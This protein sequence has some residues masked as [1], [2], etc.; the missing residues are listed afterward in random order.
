MFN[1]F[2]PCMLHLDFWISFPLNFILAIRTRG[3][4]DPDLMPK[5][6][7]EIEIRPQSLEIILIKDLWAGRVFSP[8][9]SGEKTRAVNWWWGWWFV[10]R[11]GACKTAIVRVLSKA[12]RRGGQIWW[13]GLLQ[14]GPG[15]SPWYRLQVGDRRV[16]SN[17]YCAS[18]Y[19]AELIIKLIIFILHLYLSIQ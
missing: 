14:W 18:L 1:Y 6:L 10:W 5:L 13:G 3:Q 8:S 15:P 9:L 2:P 4:K 16:L 7:V 17:G 11:I 12:T 19:W